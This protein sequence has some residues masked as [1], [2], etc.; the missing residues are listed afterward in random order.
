MANMIASE[1]IEFFKEE[2]ELLNN[3][4]DLFKNLAD[5]ATTDELCNAAVDLRNEL[6]DFIGDYAG[7]ESRYNFLIGNSFY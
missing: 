6:I 3:V 4:L 7:T 5:A 2:I 1:K